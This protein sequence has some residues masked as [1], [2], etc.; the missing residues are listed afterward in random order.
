MP[1]V[2]E[3]GVTEWTE[4]ETLDALDFDQVCEIR[5]VTR[6]MFS[7]RVGPKCGKPAD[8]MLTCRGCGYEA[9]ICAD[10]LWRITNSPRVF[11]GHCKLIG[12]PRDVF[13]I[14]PLWEVK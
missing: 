2:A 4:M 14:T 7:Q 5:Y 6:R 11:C 3:P 12:K 10:H 1:A 8:G 13:A 9:L